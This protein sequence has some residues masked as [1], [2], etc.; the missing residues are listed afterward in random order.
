LVLE[1]RSW[2]GREYVLLLG[3]QEVGRIQREGFSGRKLLLEFPDD[4]PLF[5]QLFLVYVVASQARR[6]RAAAASGG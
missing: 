6:E 5:L 2:T 1:S 4:M 3:S